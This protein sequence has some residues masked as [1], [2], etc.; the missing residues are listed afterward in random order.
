MRPLL[1]A[2]V[3]SALGLGCGPAAPVE[4]IFPHELARIDGACQPGVPTRE[5]AVS[6]E[7]PFKRGGQRRF[8]VVNAGGAPHEVGPQHVVSTFAR[9]DRTWSA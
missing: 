1:P 4:L 8:R 6:V 9:C 3:L 7:T 5:L 2:A